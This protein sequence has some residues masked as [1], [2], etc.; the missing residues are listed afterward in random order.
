MKEK[1]LNFLPAIL[2]VMISLI[3]CFQN[4]TFGTFL[5]GWDTLHPEFNFGLNFNRLIF[6]VFRP[7]QGLG[8]VA[9]H[10]HMSEI[11][12][13]I[14]LYILNIFTPLSFLRYSYIFLN[15]IIG[16]LGVY[17]LLQY[18][19]KNKTVSFL[20]GLFYL[21]NLGT[22]Q[23]FAV[24][25]EM[26]TAQYG[27]LP[28]LFFF[29]VKYLNEAKKSGKSL[30][31][32]AIT[33]VLSSP[34]AYAATLWYMGLLLFSVFLLTYSLPHAIKRDFGLLKKSATILI[35]FFLTNSFWILPNLYLIFTSGGNVSLANINQLFSPQ[36]FLYNKE[37]GN[38]KDI[39]LIKNFLFDWGVY[40]GKGN[41]GNLLEVWNGHLKNPYVL[42]SGYLFA[43]VA[44]A[45]IVYSIAKKNKLGLSLIP[46]LI[47][48]LFFLFNDNPPTGFLFVFIRDKFPL[49]R[50]ALRF[51]ADKVLGFF[52]F[53]FAFYFGMGQ[54]AIYEAIKKLS[55]ISV[56]PFSIFQIVFFSGLLIFYMSPA[57]S[58][59]LID[60]LMRVKIPDYYFET[61]KYFDGEKDN[62][63]IANF[64]VHS[65]WGWEYYDWGGNGPS[66]QGAGFI[67]FGIKQ[68]MLNRDFDRW[69]FSNEQ[70]YKEVSHAVYAK[71]ANLLKSVIEKYNIHY[72]LLDRSVIAPEN[73]QEILY[74][75]E[76]QELL[77]KLESEDF[78]VKDAQFG[79]I[80][81]YK[82]N[83]QKDLAYL[84]KN[85]VKISP[86]A[87]TYYE[88]FAFQKYGNYIN[89]SQT[90][91]SIFY[92]F[93]NLTDSLDRVFTDRIKISQVGAVLS[94]QNEE[95]NQRQNSGELE[96]YISSDLFLEKEGNNISVNI[97]PRSPISSSFTQPIKFTSNLN[98]KNYIVSVNGT[99]NFVAENLEDGAS[100]S[101]GTV[102]LKTNGEN[103]ISVYD[104]TADLSVSPDFSKIPFYIAP[105]EGKYP[106]Q[107][108]GIEREKDA[109]RIFGKNA[110]I[111]MSIAMSNIFTDLKGIDPE[112]ALLTTSFIYQGSP[113]SY[114]CIADIKTG[115][116]LSYTHRNLKSGQT[117]VNLS[118]F[119]IEKKS[120]N[121]L[122]VKIFLDATQTGKIEKVTYSNVNFSLTKPSLS[123]PFS[124]SLVKQS[125]LSSSKPQGGEVIVPFSGTS[126]FSQDITKLPRTSIN[127][128]PLSP[129]NHDIS[130]KI[131]SQEKENYIRYESD[132]GVACDHFSYQNLSQDQGYLLF[133]KSRNIEGLPLTVCVLSHKSK[134]C[135]IYASLSKGSEFH[136][137]V[138]LIPPMQKDAKGYDINIASL[139]I[140]GTRAVNDLAQIQ[141]IP[142]PYYSLYKLGEIEADK[143]TSMIISDQKYINPSLY[144]VDLNSVQTENST[145]V[146]A[147]AYE[148]G[149][150]A[151]EITNNEKRITNNFLFYLFP[152]LFGKKLDNHVMVNSW[153]NGWEIHKF[154]FTNPNSQIIIVFL[155]QYLEYLGFLLSKLTLIFLAFPILRSIL[156][157][158]KHA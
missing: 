98:Q 17:F 90:D 77:E 78:A 2:L 50:E 109:F 52:I 65:P 58:G 155:P 141:L 32:F 5:S 142:L 39:A 124:G 61:F 151:Y 150:V 63:T 117:P 119:G 84:L 129:V 154:Q 16:P 31:F 19:F 89:S 20:G 82:I 88:D 135:D 103:S 6:G 70:Y 76:T 7:E 42:F 86:A 127:C 85:P 133:M 130:K 29:A 69:N 59:R 38:L 45:G 113:S 25:F 43:L 126:E 120:I 71:D 74:L 9:V 91:G 11:P 49:F 102:A 46:S 83:G 87:R 143:S 100:F 156:S 57:F 36:A 157:H 132:K 95:L 137:N 80:T 110:P 18:L 81:I 121:D 67:W 105:C 54:L 106:D 15:L 115:A 122:S 158:R 134:H 8:A 114:A 123:T 147:K 13:V 108:V 14:F 131:L 24:P 40:T 79:K 136:D 112:N 21:L 140:V 92:P 116:C 138:F 93:R 28:W 26:F 23:R 33:A 60:P 96:N 99:D 118:F 10:S 146:F 56:K 35:V 48:V 72:I 37:F 75:D 51:P 125:L 152:F 12:R 111:C 94:F 66:Y 1:L 73:V 101:L 149:W 104:T 64:P 41:F 47:I 144:E 4:Y 62:G 139:G 55:K 3:L 97:Y 68:P 53:I 44:V 107:V 27:M 148:P 153:A 30:L 128:N 22:L 145:L 34:M